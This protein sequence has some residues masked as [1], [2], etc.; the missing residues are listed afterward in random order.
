MADFGPTEITL[1][2]K[3]ELE[4]GELLLTGVQALVR[5]PMVR[6]RLDAARGL[7]T[8]GFISGYRGSPLAT[9]DTQLAAAKPH[10]DRH[11]IVVRPA[12]NEDLAATAVWGAQLVNLYPGARYDGVFGIWYGKTP[13]VDRS[14]DVLKHAS[15]AGV[16][17]KGGVLAI[18]GDDHGAKSSSL[19]GQSEYAFVDA[20]IPVF[21]PSNIAEAL[22]FGVKAF[23][24]S[25]HAGVWTAM[26]VV[27]ELMDSSATVSV[28]AS[29]YDVIFPEL[30]GLPLDGL[31]IRLPDTP[32]AQ[33]LRHRSHRLPAAAEFIR[34]NGFDRVVI[35]SSA[36]RLCVVAQGKAYNDL[37]QALNDLGV[38]AA[39]AERLGLRV[40]KPGVVWPL[41]PSGARAAVRGLEEVLVIEER[42][43][44]V[45]EQLKQVAYDLP[46]GLRPRIVGKTDEQGRPL[47]ASAG[48]LDAAQVARVLYGRLP[49]RDR[50]D[51]MRAH[52]ARLDAAQAPTVTVHERQP[53]FCAGCP[54]NTSTK[55]PEGSRALAGIG[56]HYMVQQM[57][58]HTSSFTQMGGE[59]VSWVGQAPFTDEP[60]V[61][62]NLGDGTYFHSGSLA[63][64]QAVAAGVNITYKILFNDA[65]AMTGGQAVDGDQ[66]VSS[67]L[68]QLAAEG[69]GR[70][71][72]VSDDEDSA[73]AA[74][75]PSVGA[76]F[77]PRSELDAVQ[78]ALRDHR[79]VSALV[80]V[81]TCA[82]E[83]RRRRK[84][85]LAPDPGLRIFIN[86]R[87]CEGCGDCSAQ[88][89][90]IAVEPVETAFGRKRRIDQSACNMD[91]SCVTG[92]CPSFVTV[93]GGKPRKSRLNLDAA[94]A[95]VPEATP[96][97]L[98]D[99]A[100]NIVLAGIGGQ[101]V[102]SLAAM[103]DMAAYLD[104][105]A[106]N[107]VDMLGMAQKGGGVFVHLRLA[108]V[109]LAIASP[110][111][112][113]GQA[114]LLL[115]NDMVV[116]HGRSV[117]PLIATDR[118]AVILNTT[119]APTAEFVEHNDVQ[120]DTVSMRR[121]LAARA[122]R[123]VELDA[124]RDAVA[125]MGDAIFTN[126]FLLGH[127]WQLGLI[128]LSR[129]SLERAIE[130]NGAQ[131]A[132][133]K[134]AFAL[135]RLSAHDPAAVQAAL[136][137][138][139]AIPQDY[140]D[141]LA[142]RIDDL[143][144][145]QGP[146]YAER[147]RRAV[148][149][150]AATEAR[151]SPGSTELALAAARSL[152]RLMAYKDEYEVAR[153]YIDGSFQAA[154]KT[155]FEDHIEIRVHMAPPLLG[156]RDAEGRPLKTTFG[157][158]MVKALRLLAPFKVLR[159]TPL[160]PFGWA[161]ERRT[162]RALRDEFFTIIDEVTS[163]VGRTDVSD[164]VA[165]LKA[166][167][168]VRGYGHIKAA[169]IQAYRADLQ[170]LRAKLDQGAATGTG[171]LGPS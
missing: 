90:C 88:S 21:A 35:D 6:Q 122:A 105:G 52:I 164:L 115:A 94:L 142:R 23:D 14:G 133:N 147:Y 91:Q 86:E 62:A 152:Y 58:R 39:A 55:V 124:G 49:E 168:A 13:G 27:A 64:R 34:L 76:S 111:I 130:L 98:T 89:N 135:G 48:E 119:L 96:P 16:W 69:V 71:A 15:H 22:T 161:Q 87:V 126:M 141:V 10:L 154:L 83:L 19:T 17:P 80:Y 101:G 45:E 97:A 157:P 30:F 44:L 2:T 24:L 3:Y 121:T 40:Y 110:R 79:G 151:V 56:C 108:T 143:T 65:V 112:A 28:R 60:H 99:A 167:D 25:R 50:T 68:H 118:T 4:S 82:T 162:E 85:G 63:I 92:F 67:V 61:F 137:S 73:R 46:D 149:R 127:A 18:A 153:L 131:A 116:A 170:R 163:A 11:R 159:G 109:R 148:E 169:N 158:W 38:D 72:V 57:P 140:P 7:R 77:H 78:K 107:S 41:E 166:P 12:V 136:P 9:Y 32:L 144:A 53:F 8:A 150:L 132:A 138:V 125:L 139:P 134:Q 33:E 42:R 129:G 145:Y 43:P 106:A 47:V 31:G 117:A 59:G 113:P 156:R 171:G 93:T 36:P 54:H 123:V 95:G 84:R 51:R 103:M 26:T 120:Y 70:I 29:D 160:D 102:T 20:E 37:R 1:D 155:A 146:A 74:A 66:T 75:G 100:Y 128:P 165:L 114:D 5:L 81:Q 104:G